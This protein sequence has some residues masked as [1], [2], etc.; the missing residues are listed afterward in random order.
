MLIL[1]AVFCFKIVEC[2]P[3][4]PPTW[5]RQVVAQAETLYP[6][7]RGAL[8]HGLILDVRSLRSALKSANEGQLT[9]EDLA[10]AVGG[11]YRALDRTEAIQCDKGISCRVVDDA[12]LITFDSLKRNA[13]ELIVGVTYVST[14]TRSTSTATCSIPALLVFRAGDQGWTLH[15]ARGL[16]RC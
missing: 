1:I 10:T 11:P 12:L 14:V 6:G 5:L 2:L 3:P 16:R 13:N 8:S 7:G 15:R 9:D 4:T